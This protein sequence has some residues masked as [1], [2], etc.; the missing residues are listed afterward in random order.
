MNKVILSIG[1]NIYPRIYYIYQ[2]INAIEKYIGRI[3]KQSSVYQTEPWNMPENTAFFYNMCL[4]IQTSLSPKEIL[5]II[6]EVEQK[7]GRVKKTELPKKYESRTIDIDILFF[8]DEIV[9]TEDLI[10]PHPLLHQRE[11]VLLPLSEIAGD[12]E[13]PVLKQKIKN[14]LLCQNTFV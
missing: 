12:M 5:N 4:I 9:Q 13:H 11:F 14:L 8:N 7:M 2:A 6:K 1:S 10:I 3:E